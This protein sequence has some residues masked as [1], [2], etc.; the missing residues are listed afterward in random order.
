MSKNQVVGLGSPLPVSVPP[1]WWVAFSRVAVLPCGPAFPSLWLL[2][3]VM[4][5]VFTFL[6]YVGLLFIGLAFF[7]ALFMFPP[8]DCLLLLVSGGLISFVSLSN[9]EDL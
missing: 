6:A 9:L 2:E 7:G 8:V 3:F 4:S 1:F 5:F